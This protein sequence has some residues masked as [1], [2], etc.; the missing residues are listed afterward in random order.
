[1]ASFTS[2]A[3][4]FFLTAKSPLLVTGEE[5]IRGTVPDGLRIN[6]FKVM[7]GHQTPDDFHS[8]LPFEYIAEGELPTSWDW[9]NVT[10]GG[11]SGRSLLTHS[12]L[13]TLI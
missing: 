11:S 2:R 9:R 7:E 12:W 8:P 6:E 13:V 4:L 1:M 3:L 5:F 10:V